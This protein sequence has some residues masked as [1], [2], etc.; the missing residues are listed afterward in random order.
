MSFFQQPEFHRAVHDTGDLPPDNAAEVAFAGRSNSGKSS[1]VNAILQRKNLASVSKTPGHTRGIHFYRLDAHR[2]LVDL[3]GYGYAAGPGAER[4]RW[5]AR[6]S[7]YLQTRRSLRGLVLVCDTRRLL[8]PL[9]RQLIAWFSPTGK[10][11]HVLLTKADKLPPAQ[12]LLALTRCEGELRGEGPALTA[13]LF[14][15]RTRVGVPAAREI[16]GAW[17]K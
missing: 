4:R 3:P 6:I 13:Q 12:A 2:Y 10:P 5:D 16:L 11:V 7:A 9:D 1:A 14:S 17:L 15:G 8:T